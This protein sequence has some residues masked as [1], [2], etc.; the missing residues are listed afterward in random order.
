MNTGLSKTKTRGPLVPPRPPIGDPHFDITAM[1]D[2]VFMMNIFFLVTWVGASMAEVDLPPAKKCVA[3]DPAKCVIVTIMG[4]GGVGGTTD[5]YVGEAR[6]GPPLNDPAEIAQA[7]EEAI[8]SGSSEGKDTVLIKAE[9]TVPLREIARVAALVG[10]VEGM[11]L[12]VAVVE[13]E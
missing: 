12:R 9:K 10:N 5:H 2:L 3:T 13:K 7:V 6:S 1:V 11:E 8:R 4:G